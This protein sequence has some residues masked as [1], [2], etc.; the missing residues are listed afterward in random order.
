VGVL[1]PEGRL[2]LAKVPEAVAAHFLSAHILAP[3][4]PYEAGGQV[5]GPHRMNNARHLIS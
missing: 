1:K 2:Q 5:A 4:I 3:A